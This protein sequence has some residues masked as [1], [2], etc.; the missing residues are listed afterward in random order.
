MGPNAVRLAYHWRTGSCPGTS[1]VVWSALHTALTADVPAGGTVSGLAATVQAPLTA[2]TFCLEYDL[3]RENVTWFSWQ[4]A[5]TLQRTVSVTPAPYRVRWDAH[6]TPSTMGAGSA[7]VVTMSFTNTGTNTWAATAPNNVSLAYHWGT[8]PCP[9]TATAVWNGTHT[10]IPL[11]VA[12]GGAV[13]GL[14]ATVTAPPS[15][16]TYC[17]QYDLIR[18]GV[19]WFSWQ[20]ASML[21]VSVTV[22]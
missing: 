14:A 11:D 13:T 12:S 1:L 9:G 10:A 4:R 6:D 16:G 8:G 18:E 3:I 7:N 2:G 17:L 19:T 21:Q 15:A 20:G 5:S 22:S